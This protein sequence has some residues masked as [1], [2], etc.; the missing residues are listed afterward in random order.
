MAPRLILLVGCAG[1]GKSTYVRKH[2]PK[3]LVVNADHYFEDLARRLKKPFKEVWDLRSLGTAHSLCLQKFMAAITVGK[4]IVVVDNTNVKASDRQ[5]FAKQGL[6]YGYEVEIHV[7]SPWLHGEPD[8]SS[9]QVQDY[10]KLCYERN[11]HG[12]PL[13]VIEQQF[14]RLDLPSGVYRAGKPPEF[15]RPCLIAAERSNDE[16]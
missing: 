7:L 13:D 6:E 16:A 8:L 10:V 14:S 5:R 11:V 3:A 12:V 4:P 1:S 9:D 2:F 15:I